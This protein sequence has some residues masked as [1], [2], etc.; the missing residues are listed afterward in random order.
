MSFIAVCTGESWSL[1]LHLLPS[2]PFVT[3]WLQSGNIG[4]CIYQ[5]RYSSCLLCPKIVDDCV[6]HAWMGLGECWNRT[7]GAMGEASRARV[8]SEAGDSPKIN[9]SILGQCVTKNPEGNGYNRSKHKIY[10]SHVQTAV[11][12]TVISLYSLQ[13]IYWICEVEST[14]SMSQ[15]IGWVMLCHSMSLVITL[16][17]DC[18]TPVDRRPSNLMNPVT[19]LQCSSTSGHLQSSTP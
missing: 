15:E 4:V 12:D 2:G 7:S 1:C 17:K 19:L 10:D 8:R 16:T 18:A 6:P 3:V 9:S 14:N 13:N 5:R 11:K